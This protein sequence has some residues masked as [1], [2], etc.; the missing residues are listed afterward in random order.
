M[1]QGDIVIITKTPSKEYFFHVG[2]CAKLRYKDTDGDW[3]ADFTR[4]DETELYCIQDGY[5]ECKLYEEA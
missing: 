4:C 1:K 3:W 2:E 5:S